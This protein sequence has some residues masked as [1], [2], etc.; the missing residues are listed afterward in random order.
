MWF[1]GSD[2]QGEPSKL[3]KALMGDLRHPFSRRLAVHKQRLTRW[4]NHRILGKRRAEE[5]ETRETTLWNGFLLT[6]GI[7]ICVAS[8][9]W[10]SQRP[11]AASS[12][13]TSFSA[14]IGYWIMPFDC[15]NFLTHKI[16]T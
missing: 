11:N 14:V 16:G 7:L 1:R 5:R 4:R 9:I 15:L 2:P 8:A 12:A 10:P 13:I 6:I 3:S